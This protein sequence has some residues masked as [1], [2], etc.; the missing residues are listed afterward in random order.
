M[1]DQDEKQLSTPRLDTTLLMTSE[2]TDQTN[3][4]NLYSDTAIG[5]DSRQIYW[6][7]GAVKLWRSVLRALRD[8]GL[9]TMFSLDLAI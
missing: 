1:A 3:T 8:Q 5:A 6:C 7:Q 4:G 2:L 9:Y